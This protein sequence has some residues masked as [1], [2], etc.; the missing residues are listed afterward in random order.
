GLG[1]FRLVDFGGGAQMTFERFDDYFLGRPKLDRVVI[2]VVSDPNTLLVNV[3][4]GT[5]DLLADRTLPSTMLLPLSAEWA[6]T[7]AGQVLSRQDNWWYLWV[8]MN[9]E[10]AQPVEV[11]RDARVRQGML[12]GID[13]ESLREFMFPG[14]PGTSA[15][16]FMLQ[17]DP[18]SA[19]VGQPFARF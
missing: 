5:I 12:L 19:V 18:R 11:A 1:P 17:G 9:P 7:G 3:R 4:A 13:R 10:I 15:D 8:Q 2:Q 14:V 6:R 16:T